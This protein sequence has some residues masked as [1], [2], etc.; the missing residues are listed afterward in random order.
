MKTVFVTNVDTVILHSMTK[1]ERQAL[2]LIETDCY[3][4]E[5]RLKGMDTKNWIRTTVTKNE[6]EGQKILYQSKQKYFPKHEP[7]VK[8][9]YKFKTNKAK[10]K[11]LN[12]YRLKYFENKYQSDSNFKKFY[13]RV[14]D[15]FAK[16]IHQDY[17]HFQKNEFDKL[18]LA[19][20]WIPNHGRYF[21]KYLFILGEIAE[22]FF[23][24]EPEA[25]NKIEPEKRALKKYQSITFSKICT[26]LRGK[27]QIPEILMSA[28]KWDKI[29]YNKVPSCAMLRYRFIFAEKDQERFDHFVSTKVLKAGAITPADIIEQMMTSIFG[30][31]DW[32]FNIED[33]YKN[34][35]PEQITSFNV[36]EK[37]WKALVDDVKSNGSIIHKNALS[38]CDVSG[39]MMC[40]DLKVKP[41]HAAIGLSLFLLELSDFAWKNCLI[42]FSEE[43]AFHYINQESSLKDRIFQ[44]FT[45]NL[46][47]N[48]NL[49]AVFTLILSRAKEER[50]TNEKMPRMI[51]IFSD[52]EFDI[53]L[54]EKTNFEAIK[55]QYNDAGYTLP[56][57]I[58]WNLKG[59]KKSRSTPVQ[60]DENGVILLSGYSAQTFKFLFTLKNIHEIS[61]MKLL[62]HV[63]N[64]PLYDRVQAIDEE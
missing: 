28:Q 40:S 43:P 37:Q 3:Q 18:S 36:L 50:L 63:L 4:L 27:I 62:M 53:A 60:F 24:L 22:K 64:N 8:I 56:F 44:L 38:I 6:I 59:S 1:A 13:D 23:K 58:F 42:T 46:G 47:L 55:M 19:A 31:K 2:E 45:A 61:P 49:N 21:D 26:A 9:Y 16:Q 51:F 14:V 30:Q 52:M 10:L 48:T 39:S 12:E 17:Q 20:K 32:E 54:S 25:L 29:N 34:L 7:P 15:Y 33:K 35:S 11:K 57:V 5:R 41:L